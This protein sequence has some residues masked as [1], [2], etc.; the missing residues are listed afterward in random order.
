MMPEEYFAPVAQA[1]FG[2]RLLAL[3]AR[4]TETGPL[5]VRYESKGW[6]VELLALANDGPRYSPRVEIGPLPERGCKP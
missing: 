4:L 6:F 1:V 3:G 2:P 5:L